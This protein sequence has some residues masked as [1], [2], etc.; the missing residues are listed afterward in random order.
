MCPGTTGVERWAAVP[1]GKEHTV[2]SGDRL[3]RRDLHSEV[4][5]IGQ[6]CLESLRGDI[7]RLSPQSRKVK[8]RRI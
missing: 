6:G 5:R 8:T 3:E 4:L 7:L 1:T 2:G